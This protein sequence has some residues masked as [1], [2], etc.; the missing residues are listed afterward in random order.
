MTIKS[1]LTSKRYQG[2]FSMKCM[3]LFSLSASDTG[4]GPYNHKM[5]S[6]FFLEFRPPLVPQTGTSEL[7]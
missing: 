7:E 3:Q 4:I 6:N 1:L 2:D 5:L